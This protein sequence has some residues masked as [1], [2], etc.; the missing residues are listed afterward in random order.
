MSRIRA[1]NVLIIVSHL[2]NRPKRRLFGPGRVS[3][4]ASSKIANARPPLTRASCKPTV[5][6]PQR[7]CSSL[8]ILSNDDNGITRVTIINREQWYSLNQSTLSIIIN[9][10]QRRRRLLYHPSFPSHL[11]TF[12]SLTSCAPI[13]Y[14]LSSLDFWGLQVNLVT[15]S[16]LSSVR[17]FMTR[18]KLLATLWC[19]FSGKSYRSPVNIYGTRFV[20]PLLRI[21]IHPFFPW[22]QFCFKIFKD[23]ISALK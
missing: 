19:F 14:L 11:P 3:L 6:N 9:S 15:A 1:R 10:T 7:S 8:P 13:S 17:K 12:S 5:G 20:L 16:K 2:R 4:P 21:L 22:Y 18:R 23:N